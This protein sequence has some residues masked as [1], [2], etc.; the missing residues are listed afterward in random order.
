M[1][2]PTARRRSRVPQRA[3]QRS[4]EEIDGVVL[5]AILGTP[6]EVQVT[7]NQLHLY[8][9]RH[10]V[11]AIGHDARAFGRFDHRQRRMAGEQRR[12]RA[13]MMRRQML[14]ENNRDVRFR[15]RP[16]RS[17]VNASKPPADAPTPMMVKSGAGACAA[18]RGRRRGSVLSGAIS[19]Q[20]CDC[21]CVARTGTTHAR[22]DR[23]AAGAAPWRVASCR[24]FPGRAS[25]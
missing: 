18:G 16:S 6:A 24:R 4:K 8:V 7:V 9:G 11:H 2:C 13:R 22:A 12:E 3:R 14:D 1:R 15:G 10:H 19:S 25:R 21:A 17:C 23:A 5:R 20:P